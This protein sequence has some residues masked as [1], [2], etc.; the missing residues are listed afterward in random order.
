MRQKASSSQPM[1]PRSP[2][3]CG[4]PAA[5]HRTTASGPLT[6]DSAL[7]PAARRCVGEKKLGVN[8]STHCIAVFLNLA[9]AYPRGCV[10]LPRPLCSPEWHRWVRRG[11]ETRNYLRRWC[12]CHRRGQ[13]GQP[14]L[15]SPATTRDGSSWPVNAA[16]IMEALCNIE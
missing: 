2:G 12:H 1:V 13:R 15:Q 6:G 9:A 4:C 16:V 3:S 14:L 5:A 11:R 10:D 7:P 8:T